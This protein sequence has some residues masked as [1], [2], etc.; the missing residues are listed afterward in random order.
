MNPKPAQ[1]HFQSCFLLM[2]PILIWNL[3]VTNQLPNAF[4]PELFWNDIPVWLTYGENGSR[5]LI[6]VLTLLMPL[7]FSSRTQKNGLFLYIA[8]ILIYFATWLALIYFPHSSWSTSMPGFMAPAFTPLL[9]L[10]GIG[11]IGNSFYFTLPF[12]RWIFILS[13]LL[14]LAFHNFHTATI[15]CRIQ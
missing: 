14:F 11:L 9:W 8:G 15:Y 1:N 13:S 7:R 2:L 3:A 10:T 12:S 4:Q 5:L 6:F